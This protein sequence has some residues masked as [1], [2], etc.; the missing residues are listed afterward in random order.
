MQNKEVINGRPHNRPCYIS[1]IEEDNGIQWAIPIS[2]QIEKYKQIYNKKKKPCDTIVFG[3]V[4]GKEKAFLIQNICPITNRY[5]S[6][7]YINKSINAPVDISVTLKQELK[8]KAQKVLSLHNKGVKIIF[9]DVDKI[10]EKL[11][12][13]FNRVNVRDGSE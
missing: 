1:I 6:K 10:K 2:S 5:I 11:L 7:V 8:N 3:Y 13:E 4:L 12:E 9:P